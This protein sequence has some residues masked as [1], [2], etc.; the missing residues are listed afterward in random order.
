MGANTDGCQKRCGMEARRRKVRR[1]GQ[2]RWTSRVRS[3]PEKLMACL[4]TP[5]LSGWRERKALVAPG[6]LT[7]RSLLGEEDDEGLHA[8]SVR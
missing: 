2:C 7:R 4:K 8:T 3:S 6:T 1:N 5:A